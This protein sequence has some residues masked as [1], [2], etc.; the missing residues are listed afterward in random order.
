M[1]KL[2]THAGVRAESPWH[3]LPQSWQHRL[4]IPCSIQIA[5][6]SRIH[7]PALFLCC[8][9]VSH[10][11]RHSV[12]QAAARHPVHQAAEGAREQHLDF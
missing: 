8:A 11:G 4:S 1:L 10:A 7:L 12:C 5:R 3:K 2:L 9:F 6:S